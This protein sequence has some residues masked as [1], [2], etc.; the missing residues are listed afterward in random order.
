LNVNGTVGQNPVPGNPPA[1]LIPP[2][3]PLPHNPVPEAMPDYP[4]TATSPPYNG[5][6]MEERAALAELRVALKSAWARRA[7]QFPPELADSIPPV[8]EVRLPARRLTRY[9]LEEM[10]ASTRDLRGSK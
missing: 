4:L 6:T 9:E 5:P 10:R 7:A 1:A 8:P 2:K 3:N